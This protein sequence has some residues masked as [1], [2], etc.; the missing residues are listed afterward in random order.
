MS[1]SV[2]VI[3]H[4][5][6]PQRRFIHRTTTASAPAWSARRLWRRDEAANQGQQ[7]RRHRRRQVQDLRLRSAIASSSLVTNGQGK[8]V[9][10]AL[11]IRTRRSP[12]NWRCTVKIHCS[13][14]ARMPIKAAVA[15][16]KKKHVAE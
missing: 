8:T 6:I 4:Y 12:R 13:I 14:L 16:Y 5:E 11:D 7:E 10:Q 2:K 9:D 15:D 3:D 1:Y